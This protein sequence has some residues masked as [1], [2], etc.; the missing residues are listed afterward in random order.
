MLEVGLSFFYSH[1]KT[2]SAAK[3]FEEISKTVARDTASHVD[4]FTDVPS[5]LVES[6]V[7]L[8]WFTLLKVKLWLFAIFKTINLNTTKQ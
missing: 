8:Q 6:I 2:R 1:I 3:F 4:N 7:K 5:F